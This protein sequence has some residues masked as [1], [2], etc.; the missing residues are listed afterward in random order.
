M[1][2]LLVRLG[3]SDKEARVYLSLMELGEDTAQNIAEKSA[4]NRAT[5]YVVL[6]KLMQLGLASTAE[7]GKKTV[8]VAEDPSELANIL[9]EQKRAIESRRR[10][11]DEA[12]TELKAIY[13]ANPDKPIVRYYEGGEGLEALDRYGMDQLPEGSELVGMAPVDMIEE[14]FPSRRKAA[15]DFRLKKK[16]KSRSIYTHRNGPIAASLDKEQLREAV[17]LPREVLPISNTIQ[18]YTGWGVKFFNFD[19]ANPFGV[20]VQNEEIARNMKELF[21]LAWVGAQVKARELEEKDKALK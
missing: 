9:E 18:L 4:V 16:I 8:F 7:R 6:E 5:T 19:P 1:L 17:F 11:L 15:V 3:L 10:Y 21:E 14:Q 13:N 20:L 2:E 12:L